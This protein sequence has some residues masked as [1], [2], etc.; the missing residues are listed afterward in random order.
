MSIWDNDEFVGAFFLLLIAILLIIQRCHK[1]DKQYWKFV[2]E[3]EDRNKIFQ[4][5][6]ALDEHEEKISQ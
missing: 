1:A 5:S 3:E 4:D 6:I 2:K